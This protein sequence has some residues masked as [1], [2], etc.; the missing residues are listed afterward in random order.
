MTMIYRMVLKLITISTFI[1]WSVSYASKM[2]L[3][4][5]KA[6]ATEITH[7]RYLFPNITTINVSVEQKL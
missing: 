7:L 5:V 3:K 2:L 1:S 4:L 6:V